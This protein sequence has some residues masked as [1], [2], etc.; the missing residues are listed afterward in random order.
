[1]QESQKKE[2]ER[3]VRG[4]VQAR[5]EMD[6]GRAPSVEEVL[7]DLQEVERARGTRD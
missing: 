6:D 2:F 1:M 3:K 5:L 4:A 7:R